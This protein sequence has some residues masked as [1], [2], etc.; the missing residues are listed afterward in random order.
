M[1]ES[2]I[3]QLLK[4]FQAH[5]Q[6]GPEGLTWPCFYETMESI[7]YVHGPEAEK[8]CRVY[9]TCSQ[10]H[11]LEALNAALVRICESIKESCHEGPQP[12]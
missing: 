5:E 12:D 4:S 8:R 11:S 9:R 3:E 7:G 10:P 6:S 1:Y 2:E